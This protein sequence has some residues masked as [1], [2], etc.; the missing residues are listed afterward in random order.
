M[1]TLL[2]A[3]TDKDIVREINKNGKLDPEEEYKEE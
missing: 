2:Q 1:M 3:K